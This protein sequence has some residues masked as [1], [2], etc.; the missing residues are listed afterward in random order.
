M[1]VMLRGGLVVSEPAIVLAVQLEAD[2]HAIAAKDGI[3][4][5]TNG[6]TLS[7]HARAQIKAHRLHLLAIAAYRPPA[8]DPS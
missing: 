3:L 5:V 1:P 8:I 6:A 2:G 4:T 7:D